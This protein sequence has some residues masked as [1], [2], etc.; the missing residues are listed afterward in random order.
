MPNGPESMLPSF[1]H[2]SFL[3]LA[4]LAVILQLSDD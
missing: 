1:C 2:F 4:L 3:S